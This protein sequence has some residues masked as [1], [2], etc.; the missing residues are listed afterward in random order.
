MVMALKT[1]GT[2]RYFDDLASAQSW[3]ASQ[4]HSWGAK[5]FVG[6]RLAWRMNADVSIS[7][8]TSYVETRQTLAAF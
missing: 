6:G 4:T 1:D 5:I 8:A 2:S 7:P 3:L